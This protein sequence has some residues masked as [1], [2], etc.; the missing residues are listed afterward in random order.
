MRFLISLLMT[1]NFCL[2]A[3]ADTGGM[4]KYTEYRDISRLSSTPVES[5][6]NIGRLWECANIYGNATENGFDFTIKAQESYRIEKLTEP[7]TYKLGNMSFQTSG[8]GLMQTD[9]LIS[10]LVIRKTTN[11]RIIVEGDMQKDGPTAELA[12]NF[13]DSLWIEGAAVFTYWVCR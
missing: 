10:H 8:L 11:G 5:D 4:Q 3:H 7:G 9:D 2:A 6:L 12:K 13:P 1:G